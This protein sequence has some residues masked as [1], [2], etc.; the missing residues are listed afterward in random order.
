[1]ATPP[2]SGGAVPPPSTGVVEV[3]L[4]PPL[5]V[6]P[7]PLL[8]ACDVEPCA[9]ALDPT[10][11][12][13][14]LVAELEVLPDPGWAL[15]DDAPLVDAPELDGPSAFPLLPVPPPQPDAPPAEASARDATRD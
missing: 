15:V 6:D 9:L 14:P 8:D 11:P 1:M 13:D 10:M 12:V 4:L 7:A 3:A 5:L 2:S